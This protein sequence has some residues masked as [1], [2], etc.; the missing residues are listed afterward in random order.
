MNRSRL[1]SLLLFLALGLVGAHAAPGPGNLPPVDLAD[2]LR[3]QLATDLEAGSL[4][5]AQELVESLSQGLPLDSVR[6]QGLV[7][8]AREALRPR[9]DDPRAAALL[10]SLENPPRAS[11]QHRQDPRPFVF[12]RD[13]GGHGK[14]SEWWYWNGHLQTEDGRR[15]GFQLCYFHVRLGLY[16]LHAAVTDEEGE[17]FTYRR[18]FYR[19]SKC[20]IRQDKLHLAYGDTVA[21]GI[22]QDRQHFAFKV[23]PYHVSLAL[24]PT[25]GIMNV[26]G[27]GLID[28]PEGTT[29]RYYSRTSLAATGSVSQDGQVHPVTGSVWFDHQW[30]NFWAMFR[31][32]DWFC[33]QME[34]GTRYNL[35]SFRKVRWHEEETYVNVLR[36][37]GELETYRNLVIHRD[38]WWRSPHTKKHYVVDWTLD[39]PERQEKM[40]I[41]STLDD[42]EMYRVN[43]RD[44]PPTYWEGSLVVERTNADG[45]IT[46]G[47]SYGEHFPY[48]KKW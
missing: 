8:V 31:P 25:R 12:P 46:H 21:R 37:D 1:L 24:Q 47:R 35:F 26:N 34:D 28:M 45:S 4:D 36:P 23:G 10:Q 33:V 7:E 13:E 15:F 42:Q 38:R 48:K 2:A 6:R 19:P 22:G 18:N 11:L 44:V 30:G 43:W 32:W 16:F 29:S 40:V 9:R 14:L 39:F 3:E 41:R 27:N 5:T 17:T 20:E